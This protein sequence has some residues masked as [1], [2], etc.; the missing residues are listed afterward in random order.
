[1]S[2]ILPAKL[3]L[4]R[5]LPYR[6]SV[7]SNAVSN[8]I[9]RIYRQRFN[10]KIHEWRL[11]AV[12]AER[13]CSTPQALT[14]LTKMDKIS[15]SRAAKSLI[16]AGLVQA[17]SNQSDGRSHYLSLT[18]RGRALYDEISAGALAIERQLLDDFSADERAALEAMLRRIEAAAEA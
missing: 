2:D 7:A 8:R 1:M 13:D 15:V 10:L 5:F 18:P 9:A 4:D 11:V 6:L 3:S 12:L 17:S 14:Q 16:G